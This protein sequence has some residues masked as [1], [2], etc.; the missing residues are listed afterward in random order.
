M[1]VEALDTPTL[2]KFSRASQNFRAW[3]LPWLYRCPDFESNLAVERFD[4]ALTL[5]PSLS[6]LVN[7]LCFGDLDISTDEIK[8]TVIRILTRCKNLQLLKLGESS[9][10][11]GLAIAILSRDLV[12]LC[13]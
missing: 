1:I 9:T 4:F 5:H 8:E 11:V 13:M 12:S 2:S 3:S 10:S 7:G 6:G